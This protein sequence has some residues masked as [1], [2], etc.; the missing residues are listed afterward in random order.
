MANRG[1]KKIYTDEYLILKKIHRSMIDR[2]HNILSSKYPPY[3]GRG[4]RV[5]ASWLDGFDNFYRDMGDR[6]SPKYSLDRIDNDGPYSP[7]NCRWAT[8]SEQ[9]R[10]TSKTIRVQF[11]GEI[12]PLM[13]VC[14]QVGVPVE[15]IRAR[16]K[17]GW[18][19]ERAISLP[20]GSHH[21]G[22][23]PKPPRPYKLNL[24]HEGETK[25]L[26]VWCLEKGVEY[27]TARNR[28]RQGKSSDEILTPVSGSQR[29]K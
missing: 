5:C 18:T 9:G 21:K 2:C 19:F 26:R 10:N 3:G 20:K 15:R 23:P 8:A 28:M 17:A 29:R 13:D 12:R 16:L 14:E 25:P 24:T 7:E 1:R 27:H 11:E 6:P 4:I 22:K